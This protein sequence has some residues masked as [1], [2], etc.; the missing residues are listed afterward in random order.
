MGRW[1]ARDNENLRR[2]PRDPSPE[3]FGPQVESAGPRH[4][5]ELDSRLRGNDERGLIFGAGAH[6][7]PLTG[8]E[9]P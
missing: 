5:Y 9:K 3:G 2:R 7:R 6:A 8:T 4:N 1:P